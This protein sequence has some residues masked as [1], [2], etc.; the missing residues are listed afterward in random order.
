MAFLVR[1]SFTNIIEGTLQSAPYRSIYAYPFDVADTGVATF[2]RQMLCLGISDVS[3]A[4]S[5]HAG[6]F[7]RPQARGGAVIFPEDSVA[8]FDPRLDLYGELRPQPHSDTA[9]RRVLIDLVDD[10]RLR[11]HGWTVLLHN[12]RLGALHPEYTARNAF[13]D[14]YVYSLCPMNDAVFEYA[15]ALCGDL[16]Q[17]HSLS[18]LVIETPGWLPF[19]HGYHH[20]FAQVRSNGW[21]EAMLGLC[22]CASCRRGLTSES[23]DA[24]ALQHRV[25]TRIRNYLAAPVDAASDQAASWIIADL[26]ADAELMLLI[27][28][29]QRRVNELAVAIRA[30]LGTRTELAI[31]P[32]V[33]RP[34]ALSLFEGSDL[35][36]LT[37][38]V[39][40][41]EVPFYEPTAAR[42]AADV[43]H[44]IAMTGGTA[45]IRAILRPGPPDL[46]D[47]RETAAALAALR[48]A[49]IEQWAFYNY[50]LLRTHHL[51]ALAEQLKSIQRA[52]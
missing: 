36:A 41:L 15:V 24:A 47:G 18:S 33:Q 1:I 27:R 23:A 52:Q 51:D 9:M 37:G 13:S 21:L 6:K 12:S 22:F 8:Y 19:V 14:A 39:D 30:A 25:A 31:I 44:T 43:H 7:L 28:L 42:V 50:G 3:L 34:T 48:S 11:V 29:R 38:V 5:Y 2:A 49:G 17:H 10:G 4:V 20:E 26:V 45:G 46:S 32:T 35:G 16:A 40:W